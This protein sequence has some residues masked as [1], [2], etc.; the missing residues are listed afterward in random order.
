MVFLDTWE[1]FFAAQVGASAAL[2]GLIFVGVSINMSKILSFPRL[3]ERALQSLVA[4]MVVL[5]ISSLMLVPGQ[6]TLS[7]G[8][9][10]LVVG[11]VGWLMNTRSDYISWRAFNSNLIDK[12]LR[13]KYIYNIAMTQAAHLPYIVAGILIIPFGDAAIYFVVPAMIFSFFKAISDSWV[14][15]VEI[16]R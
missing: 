3:P 16:N 11:T 12:Q 13:R 10:I 1:T 5:T 7:M 15:L 9:E 2:A 6:G 14:L 8:T 4:L